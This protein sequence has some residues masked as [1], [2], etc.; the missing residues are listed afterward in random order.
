LKAV[1]R[2]LD[3]LNENGECQM[4]Y[5]TTIQKYVVKAQ[6]SEGITRDFL[7]KYS[8]SN[9]PNATGIDGINYNELMKIREETHEDK[10]KKNY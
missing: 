9:F 1:V 5:C 2:I 7:S 3:E 4:I 6:L 10:E 8:K